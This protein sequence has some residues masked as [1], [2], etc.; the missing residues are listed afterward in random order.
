ML[1]KRLSDP[2]HVEAGG[3]LTGLGFLPMQTVFTREKTRTQVRGKFGQIEGALAGLSGCEIEGY[4]IHMG[5]TTACA[6]ADTAEK[7][8]AGAEVQVSNTDRS[9]VLQNLTVLTDEISGAKKTDGAFAENV[10]GTYVHG[11]F[12][13]EG[14]VSALVQ[15]LAARR[16]ISLDQTEAL[17]LAEYR[18]KQFDLL[19][20]ALREHLDM[21]YIYRVVGEN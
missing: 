18:E 2:A 16:G 6:G 1:G 12:D 4:E 5:E 3:E 21:E 20:A 7:V 17:S 9:V 13:A 11:I 14:M 8:C 15:S 10:Y 19:A